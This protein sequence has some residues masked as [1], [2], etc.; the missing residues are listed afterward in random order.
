MGLYWGLFLDNGKKNGTY[1][2][3]FGGLGFGV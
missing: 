2:N 3:G 1:H